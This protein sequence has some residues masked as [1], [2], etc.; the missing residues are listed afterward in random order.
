MRTRILLAG[1]GTGGHLYPALN[2]ASA[3]RRRAAEEPRL[4]YVGAERGLEA[5]VLP[6]RDLPYRLLPMHPIYR[7]R[8]WRNWRLLAGL[9]AVW[10]GLRKA[11]R[12]LEPHLV[13]GT[14]G[15]ASGPPLLYGRRT[16]RATALQEQNAAPGLVT[17]W[18]AS[19]VDQVHL[20]FPEARGL[21]RPDRE[22]R[23]F[24]HGNPVDV[25]PAGERERP[26][27][28]PEGRV[29]LVV[30]G[31][32]GAR[33]LNGRLLE[34][35]RSAE[36]WPG[37]EV[38]LVWIA[39]PAHVDVVRQGVAET[40]WADRVRVVP[41]V[42]GLGGLLSGVELAVCRAGAMFVSELTAAGVPSVLVPFPDAAGGHQEENAR[43]LAQAGAAEVR[44]EE[45]LAPGELWEAVCGVLGD[46]ERRDAMA[47][48]A[49]ER[50]RPDAADR[51]ADDLLALAARRA[52]PE[53][54][55][56]RDR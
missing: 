33:G 25:D 12:D 23:V 48:A 36:R 53:G 16:G 29:A 5:R 46:P 55:D 2:L 37:Q 10:W 35:L 6:E 13:V 18:M 47:S 15:Y 1:G 11:F 32:Q 50:G 22:T 27:W 44:L 54:E 31:S 20:G 21:I 45:E 24:S 9:P 34:D 49:A 17:R 42:E 40:P 19:R 39:G 28:W 52:G 26:P 51:I 4:M 30:G 3:L 7:S 14:G 38:Q 43:R 41:F 56:G 8:T